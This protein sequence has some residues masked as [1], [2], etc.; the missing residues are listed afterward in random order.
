ML[1]AHTLGGG[2]CVNIV[3]RLYHPKSDD[4]SLNLVYRA[5]LRLKCP[6]RVPLTNLTLLSSDLTPVIFD[7]Q[8]YKD[9]VMGK[10]LFLIDSRLWRDHR[11]AHIVKRFAEDKGHFFQVFSSAFLK[12]SKTNIIG[13]SK[14]EIRKHCN[15]IN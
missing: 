9:L 14:G 15:R 6:T 1:G 5:T 7:N 11:T 2:H 13:G 12:L 8:Y 10:G 3:D 4:H